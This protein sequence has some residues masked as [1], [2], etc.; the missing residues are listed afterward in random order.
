MVRVN[1]FAAPDNSLATSE[2]VR[3]IFL[4]RVRRGVVQGRGRGP[5]DEDGW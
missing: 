4:A 3:D 5:V 2:G 1:C